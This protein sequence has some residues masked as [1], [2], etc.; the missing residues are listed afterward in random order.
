MTTTVYRL[1]QRTALNVRS[2]LVA[3]LRS[4]SPQSAIDALARAGVLAVPGPE[5]NSIILVGYHADIRKLLRDFR[6]YG[7]ERHSHYTMGKLKALARKL[8]TAV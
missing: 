4:T 2:C 5:E 6:L 3:H 1:P 8:A 7:Y